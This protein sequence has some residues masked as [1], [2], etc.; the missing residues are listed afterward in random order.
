MNVIL[1]SLV[2]YAAPQVIKFLS[3]NIP[4]L[5]PGIAA[6]QSQGFDAEQIL[7]F[8]GKHIKPKNKKAADE[9]L[10][11]YDKYLSNIGIKTKAEREE[12]RNNFL[13]GALGVGAGALGLYG[14]AKQA[15]SLL[16]VARTGPNPLPQ[17]PIMTGPTALPAPQPPQTITNQPSPM[18]PI[19]P[20]GGSG[21]NQPVNVA[22]AP[23]LPPAKT[24]PTPQVAQPPAP[25]PV[26]Q[27]PVRPES[28]AIL[29]NLGIRLKIEK[30][31]HQGHEPNTIIQA[32]EKMIPKEL[33]G[34]FPVKE[35]VSDY[36]SKPAETQLGKLPEGKGINYKGL[37][38][39]FEDKPLRSEDYQNKS[40]PEIQRLTGLNYPE[41]K[42]L[43]EG[44]EVK[45]LDKGAL[46]LTPNGKVSEVKAKS[47]TGLIVDE[48]G[49]GTKH[50]E[51]D[52][53][54]E[55]EDVIE[56][57]NNILKIP[58]VDRSSVVSLFTYDPE[59]KQM[60]IQFH[61]G[62]SFKYYGIEPE[63]V[64][65]IAEKNGTPV[66]EGKNVFGAWSPED[67]KSLGAALIQRVISNPKYKKP[68]KGEPPNPNYKKLDT[69]YDFYEKLRKK[70]K[71]KS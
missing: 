22:K 11:D 60:I 28:G 18:P 12:T 16:N 38:E 42:R 4:K 35:V 57:V 53:E 14:T 40:V 10:N 32:A 50:Q 37:L 25:E 6:A 27:G 29:D 1:Q 36:L 48:G 17:G 64:K 43:K 23:G 56:I 3:Q 30:M 47:P 44:S 41:A 51:E 65:E 59:D 61:N 13:K 39:P 8:L 71:R 70:P 15:Q 46:V 20:R 45:P 54:Q 34:Q 62:E 49:K 2:G 33:R 5:A 52:L 69:L 19:G 24:L 26:T 7:K 21:I 58:E 68:K 31:R 9:N 67:K 55:P 66:T 63:E